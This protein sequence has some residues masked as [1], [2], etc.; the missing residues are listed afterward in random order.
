VPLTSIDHANVQDY[1]RN[2]APEY[3]SRANQTC[4]KAYLRLVKRFLGDRR[5]VLELGSG[6]SDLLDRLGSPSAVACDL[7]FDMLRMRSSRYPTHR[8]EGA[9]ESLP[10]L[11]AQF[12]GLFLI[13]LLEHVVEPEAVLSECARVLEEDGIWLAVTPNGAWEFWL[14]L[15]ERWS[16][17]IPEGP[18]SFLTPQKLLFYVQKWFEVLDHRT[19]LVLPV[20]PPGL[21]RLIDRVTFCAAL[22]GGFFQYVVARKRRV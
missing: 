21:A 3:G 4:E 14:D 5:R 16:L 9:G 8:V 20:G 18:H 1:Y 13:N 19:F 22:G 7:S 12:D 2:L 17:K 6:S 10:F 11:N 15:A